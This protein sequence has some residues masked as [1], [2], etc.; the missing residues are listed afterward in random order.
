VLKDGEKIIGE[1]A[2]LQKELEAFKLST[3]KI[4]SKINGVSDIW[5]DGNYA[6]LQAQVGELAK[7]A[8]TVIENGER[9]CSS[10][11]QFFAIVAEEA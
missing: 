4:S 3:G 8:K 5:R 2:I 10:I 1:S 9:A 6:S 11:D 7:Q